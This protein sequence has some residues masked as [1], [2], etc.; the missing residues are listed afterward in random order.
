MLLDCVA[1]VRRQRI[2]RATLDARLADDRFAAHAV[3]SER[4]RDAL[5]RLPG[6]ALDVIRP[7]DEKAAVRRLERRD[8][9]ALTLQ[10]TRPSAVR[11]KTRPAC[12]TE[13]ED[14]GVGLHRNGAI[15]CVEGEALLA[16]P[17]GPVV[18]Q[19]ELDACAIE[20]P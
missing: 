13:C 11:T 16:V 17:S 12:A 6:V 8:A 18:P 3:F 19:R 9:H 4:E 1:N 15:G 2:D 10:Q 20:P 5:Q 14:R 7:V